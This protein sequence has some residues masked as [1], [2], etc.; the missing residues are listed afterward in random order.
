MAWW[1]TASPGDPVVCIK[2]LPCL[3]GVLHKGRVYRI[4]DLGTALDPGVLEILPALRLSEVVLPVE[5][6]GS[7]LWLYTGWFRPAETLD[8]PDGLIRPLGAPRAMEH[9][10]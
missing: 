4:R 9:I 10:Q 2:V 7:E 3:S 5:Q 8:L 6:P 1:M